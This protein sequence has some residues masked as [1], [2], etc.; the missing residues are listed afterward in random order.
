MH[1]AGIR[2]LLSQSSLEVGDSGDMR[3]QRSPAFILPFEKD[4]S[5]GSD[6]RTEEG[7]VQ[8]GHGQKRNAFYL[9]EI[10]L[11][12]GRQEAQRGARLIRDFIL[13]AL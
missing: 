2:R 3:F 11:D 7:R 5:A 8:R 1:A 13:P 9:A 6:V 4:P 10:Q 12:T